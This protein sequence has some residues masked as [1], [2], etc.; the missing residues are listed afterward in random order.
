[1]SISFHCNFC[2]TLFGPLLLYTH[3]R[4]EGTISLVYKNINFFNRNIIMVVCMGEW[5]RR[6]LWLTPCGDRH[7][8]DPTPCFFDGSFDT[9]LVLW[10]DMSTHWPL[11]K[12]L[13]T[14]QLP[15]V[16]KLQ[17]YIFS[18]SIHVI[19]FRGPLFSQ[20]HIL[21]WNSLL[22]SLSKVIC[23]IMSL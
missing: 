23:N 11:S 7:I 3:G 20:V 12:W 18:R 13:T 15:G 4:K 5:D 19:Y 2:C 22:I 6:Q 16:K 14:W 8:Q 17:H 21:F 1:M 9:E 10:A